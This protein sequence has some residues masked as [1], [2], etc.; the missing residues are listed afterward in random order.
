MSLGEED[1]APA[2]AIHEVLAGRKGDL[3]L[4][5]SAAQVTAQLS[6]AAVES[7]HLVHMVGDVNLENGY[8]LRQLIFRTHC[9]LSQGFDKRRFA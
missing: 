9:C 5:R 2:V 3:S 7:W 6:G 8:E 1:V 4:R